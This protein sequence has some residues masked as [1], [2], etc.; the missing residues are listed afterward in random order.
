MVRFWAVVLM[1]CVGYCVGV[2]ADETVDALPDWR[3]LLARIVAIEERLDAI[4]ADPTV[5]KSRTVAE[6][7]EVVQSRPVLEVASA[8][9]C[10]P[11]QQFWQ[12]LKAAGDVGV[13]VK[14]VN[15]S[16][17]IPA[18]RWTTSDGKTQ[19]QTGY[20]RGTLQALLGKVVEGK[21]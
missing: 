15:F 17:R 1:A 12:D 21:P 3:V 8:E 14:R 2:V 5:R 18:F 9:W 4:E 13:E 16:S 11:C 6:P 19:T 20:T 7:L 10:G